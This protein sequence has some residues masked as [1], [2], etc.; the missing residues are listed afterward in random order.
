M[1]PDVIY[2]IQ[3]D[4][5]I[6]QFLRDYSY[7]YKYL[8]RDDSYMKTIEKLAKKAYHMTISDQLERFQNKLSLLQA[9][10]DVM[11]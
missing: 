4:P 5:M 3:N 6:H 7:H 8:Y 10:M 9:F 2:R 1:S 11:E